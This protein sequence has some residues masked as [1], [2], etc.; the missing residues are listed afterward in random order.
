MTQYYKKNED[1]EFVAADLSQ[2]DINQA[3]KERVD[4][5]NRKYSDYDELK[6]Q[7]EDFSSKQNEFENQING[8]LTDK[9]N[10][11]DELKASKLEA[12]KVRII[13]EF[14]IGDDLAEF[15]TGENADEMRA[16]AEKLAH[17]TIS[18]TAE[19]AK[20]EKPEPIKSDMA[21]LADS[22]FGSNK[23]N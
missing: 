3:V 16:R 11:E 22:L 1:G 23:A 13:S 21:E 7:I 4:R 20:V 10:L 17:N 2:E 5:I 6:K 15:V 19:V 9:A 8:L 18:K 12:E 14:K